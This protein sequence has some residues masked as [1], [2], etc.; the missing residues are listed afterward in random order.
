MTQLFTNNAASKLAANITAA[1]TT[2]TLEAGD[3]AK[4]P[5]PAAGDDFLLTLYQRNGAAEVNHEI[6]LCTARAGD[7][8]TVTRAQE[9]TTARAFAAGDFTEL[10]LT[11]G[12]VLPVRSGALT[13]ALNEAPTVT[14][15]SAS[16]ITVGAIKGNTITVTGTANISTF[17]V[18]A[19]GVV[20]RM[21]FQGALT[22][23]HNTNALTLLTGAN[24]VT[25]AGDWCEWVSAGGGKWTMMAYTRANGDSLGTVSL[26]K[27][28]TG[29]ADAA[30][31]RTNLGIG[32]VENK[33]SATIRSEITSANVTTALTFTPS[34]GSNY[35]V[36][37]SSNLNAAIVSG[38]IA[39]DGSELVNAPTSGWY[40][41]LTMSHRG[42]STTSHAFAMRHNQPG[43]VYLGAA[44]D[45]A[46]NEL[47]RAWTWY[48]LWHSGNDGTGSGLDA[49]LLDGAHADTNA[50]N[51]TIV[52]RTSQGYIF[53]THVNISHAAAA[54]NTDTVF[55]SSID[56]FIYKNTAAGFLASLG[57]TNVEQKANKDASG[58]YV[59][60][61]G[62][63]INFANAAGTTFSYIQNN[64]TLAR[65][66]TFPDK[67]G[68][69]AMMDDLSN[70][71][72]GP[73]AVTAAATVGAGAFIYMGDHLVTLQD[74]TTLGG[75]RPVLSCP[76]NLLTPPATLKT[77]DGWTV[78]TGF[79]SAK[80]DTIAP[81]R[82]DTAHGWWGN[83]SVTPPVLSQVS[84][85]GSNMCIHSSVQLSATCIVFA[86]MPNHNIDT[87]NNCYFYAVNPQTGVVNYLTGVGLRGGATEA[88]YGLKCSLFAVSATQFAFNFTVISSV[89]VDYDEYGDPIYQDTAAARLFVGTIN[90][91]NNALASF[92]DNLVKNAARWATVPGQLTNG[93][94]FVGAFLQN[95]QTNNIMSFN[96]AGN[97]VTL[98]TTMATWGTQPTPLVRIV[99]LTATTAVIVGPTIQSYN[100]PVDFRVAT[101]SG[102]TVTL[103]TT[104]S[105]SGGGGMY[106]PTYGDA[107]SMAVIPM[108][109]NKYAFFGRGQN[110]TL[111]CSFS[112][113]GTVVTVSPGLSGNFNMNEQVQPIKHVI[114]SRAMN[115]SAQDRQFYPTHA[116]YVNHLQFVGSANNNRNRICVYFQN[117]SVAPQMIEALVS[118]ETQMVMLCQPPGSTTWFALYETAGPSTYAFSKGVVANSYG[119]KVATTGIG[120]GFV[121]DNINDQAASYGGT[122]YSLTGMPTAGFPLSA[123]KY[124]SITSSNITTYGAVS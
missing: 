32:S 24:I 103:G 95:S 51:D 46:A 23:V 10:R 67:S 106:G 71:S 41:Y 76:S 100:I 87:N 37:A 3:G 7:V 74:L 72:S 79:A 52:R 17:D 112:V 68:T 66:Y 81:L 39:F 15:A 14:V 43:D 120:W 54:R 19:A 63:K 84:N 111:I 97:G 9:G 49:D 77:S 102:N 29:A 62:R 6:V 122:W 114:R 4:F 55:Y 70:I 21:T 58:G 12:A 105:S 20:R 48:K 117:T 124:I 22:L 123:D 104:Y 31:A 50:T 75:K 89:L 99:G 35:N 115:T 96:I 26:S 88:N 60:L 44:S 36:A 33:S 73:T 25:A 110:N 83:R 2:I 85:F 47:T 78:N 98:G 56:G 38:N 61:S 59:G 57:L 42:G 64:N 118:A 108:G 28:G 101:V 80:T 82:A 91:A 109:N 8:L 34:R 53:G 30:G 92:A 65:D 69:V 86:M 107:I 116:D 121:T 16:A 5:A 90:A 27:G 45:V 13:S 119:T 11:A 93:T 40:N 94:T 1:A 113:A 18:A